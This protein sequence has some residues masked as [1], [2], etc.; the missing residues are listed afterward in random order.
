[1]AL[2]T[3]LPALVLS[4]KCVMLRAEGGGSAQICSLLEECKVLCNDSVSYELS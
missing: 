2:G 3:M 4:S 1:M